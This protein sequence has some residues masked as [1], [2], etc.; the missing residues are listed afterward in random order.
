MKRH[1]L[2]YIAVM[3]ARYRMLLQYRAAAFAGFM[4]QCFWGAIRLMILAAFYAA[5]RQEQPMTLPEIVTYVWLGQ[6]FFGMLPWNID[7]EFTQKV[8]E[9]SVAYDLL[10]PLDLYAFWYSHTLAYRI[11][12]TTLR[13]IPMGLFAMLILPGLGLQ[14][15]ALQPPP[16]LLSGVLFGVSLVAAGVLSAA[17]TLLSQLTLLWTISAV[18]MD[19]IMPAVVTLFSGMVV[20]L[21]LFPDWLQPMLRWQPFRGLVD[22]PFRIYSGN[23]TP[24]VAL[25]EI[26]Q[27]GAWVGLIVWLSRVLLARGIRKLVVQGG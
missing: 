8:R 7:A 15:W 1:L 2:P 16:S 22:V 21:P 11:A 6:A 4:T 17:I 20:P 10:R 26:V 5:S 14:D 23:I 9:G 27:Q 12:P 24:T 3:S 25:Y 18:G 19:R 13:F